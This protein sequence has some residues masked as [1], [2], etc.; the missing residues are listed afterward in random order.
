MHPFAD[1]ARQGRF[2]SWQV[3]ELQ[4]YCCGVNAAGGDQPYQ[5]EP[6]FWS[7]QYDLNIQVLGSC[8][9]SGHWIVREYDNGQRPPHSRGARKRFEAVAAINAVAIHYRASLISRKNI[10]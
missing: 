9:S 5:E 6:W 4:A 10:V 2:E 1:G 8:V 3:A 7:D